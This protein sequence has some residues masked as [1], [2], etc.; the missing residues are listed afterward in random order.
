MCPHIQ[1]GTFSKRYV[2]LCKISLELLA[3]EGMKVFK[4]W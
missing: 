1:L 4:E 3:P 2:V